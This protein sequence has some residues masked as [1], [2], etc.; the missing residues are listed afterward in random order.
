VLLDLGP[1]RAALGLELGDALGVAANEDVVH[2]RAEL[3]E[4]KGL[5]GL[6]VVH[7][8]LRAVLW[9]VRSGQAWWRLAAGG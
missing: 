8:E 2:E 1:S 5:S 3:S 9:N 6:D 4:R 7:E